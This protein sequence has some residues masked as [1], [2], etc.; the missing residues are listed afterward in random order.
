MGARSSHAV[1]C[2]DQL[3]VNDSHLVETATD[4]GT[5][6]ND[7]G[8]NLRPVLSCPCSGS[9]GWCP[10]LLANVLRHQRGW[11]G[12]AQP[13]DLLFH[14]GLRS[15]NNTEDHIPRAISYVGSATIATGTPL[16]KHSNIPRYIPRRPPSC[17]VWC[18][19][20]RTVFHLTF[21]GACV[22]RRAL[23]QSIG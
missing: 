4:Q 17:H 9:A 2:L 10:H 6:R 7:Q 20:P 12:C 22:I 15:P 19:Q 5:I 16:P 14:S 1:W 13:S 21:P 11:H 23:T 3:Q 8:C 18:T